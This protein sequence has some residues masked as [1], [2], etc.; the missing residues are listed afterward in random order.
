MKAAILVQNKKPLVI[1]EVE[2]PK[3][4]GVWTSVGQNFV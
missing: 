3:R 1:D 2:L 4:V